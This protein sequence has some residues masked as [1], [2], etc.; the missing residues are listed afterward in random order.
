MILSRSSL[1]VLCAMNDKVGD[2]DDSPTPKH[3]VDEVETA[4]KLTSIVPSASS[5]VGFC[6]PHSM[7]VYDKI[8]SREVIVLIDS[9][10]SHNFITEHLVSELKVSH[11]PT[12][13]FGVQMG[14]KD[15]IRAS[16]VCQGLC[17]QLLRSR[18]LHISFPCI[19][20]LKCGLR[21]LVARLFGRFDD[22]LGKPLVTNHCG[23]GESQDTGRP[24]HSI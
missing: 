7:K 11:H 20:L 6:S 21:F 4:N 18:W 5:L 15:A 16:T 23:R 12:Q 3:D 19:R 10:A 8:K 13:E 14:N 22:A 17:L 1:Q 9:S 2:K 24:P